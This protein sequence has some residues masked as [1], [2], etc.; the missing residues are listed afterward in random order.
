MRAVVQPGMKRSNVN[1]QL[2]ALVAVGVMLT[3][4]S[5]SDDDSSD[6][7]TVDDGR[8]VD[9][10]FAPLDEPDLDETE[11]D[12]DGEDDEDDEAET[13]DGDVEDVFAPPADEP[14]DER[15]DEPADDSAEDA[16]E[17]PAEAPMSEATSDDAEVQYSDEGAAP[18]VGAGDDADGGLFEPPPA[19]PTDRQQD[20]TFEDYGYRD[21]VETREDPLSTF[22]LDVDTGSY[23]VMRRWL[24]EGVLPPVES[25]RPEEYVNAFEYDYDAP[26]SGLEIS[27]DGGPSPF[28]DDHQL[29]RIGVQAEVVDDDE[30]GDAA[31]TFVV[32]T[33]GSMDRDDRLGLVKD[34]LETLVDELEDDDTVAIVTYS[35]SSG[36]VLHPTPVSER[37]DILDAID[38]LRPGGSTNLESGLR[39]GYGLASEAYRAGGIN[40]VVLA[41]DGVANV[42]VTDPDEL[43]RMIRDDADRGINLVTVGFGMGNFNDVT[44][45]QLADQGDGF[46]AY[47]DNDD[48]AERL[49]EDELTSTLLTV[50]KDAKIQVEFDPDVVES[51]R[52]IGFEN[53]GVRDSDFRNDEVDAGELGAGHQVT[54]IY[55]V[56]LERGIDPDDRAELG[57]VSLR[58]EDPDDGDVSEIDEDIDLRDIDTEWDDTAADFRLATVVAVYAELLRDNPYADTIDIDA[59]A[60]EAR[61]L[62]DEIDDDEVDELADLVGDAADLM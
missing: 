49:F 12:E 54:A 1:Q 14:A 22:A 34:S 42:G 43:A 2:A 36:V 8:D 26:G 35:D 48:E 4:C 37:D 9:D 30:R 7:Q 41:S 25:V 56:E 15:S 33:S 28:D 53:R 11:D 40:R 47:V 59:L 50:A 62:A 61:R 52:L 57:E 29:V 23:T 19:P 13:R 10:V 39:T 6:A 16:A 5:G 18:T 21:F 27:V 60:A 44:M 32:D 17:E 3:A 46:Y 24:D 20:N 31:L 51:Y 55:E 38:A 45:E 58:W